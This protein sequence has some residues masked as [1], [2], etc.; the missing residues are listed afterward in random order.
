M[1]F[2]Y[3]TPSC[4]YCDMAKELLK[5]KRIEYEY[6]DVT[7]DEGA[8]KMFKEN[9]FRTVPQIFEGDKHIGGF[10]ELDHYIKHIRT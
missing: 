4:R 1:I 2:V 7:E 5:A 9:S 10:T 8:G 6:V 3:G